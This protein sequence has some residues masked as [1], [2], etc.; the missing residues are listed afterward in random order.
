VAYDERLAARV[1]AVL[2][3]RADVSERKIL[4]GLTFMIGGSMCCG[5][6]GDEL[7]VRLG[8]GHEGDALARPRARPMDFTGRRMRGFIAVHPRRPDR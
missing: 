4:G 5:V 6:S 8:P 7:I 2:A 1:R 3:S